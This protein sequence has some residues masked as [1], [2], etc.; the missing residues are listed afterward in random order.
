M[1]RNRGWGVQRAVKWCREVWQVSRSQT[2]VCVCGEEKGGRAR[3]TD[4]KMR[5]WQEQRIT[6]NR[7]NKQGI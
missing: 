1:T 4:G 6:L 3:A 2:G 7:T 5:N